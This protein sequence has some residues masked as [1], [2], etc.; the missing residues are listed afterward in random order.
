[1]EIALFGGTFDPPH[2][3]HHTVALSACQE[4]GFD[5]VWWIPACSPPHKS[6]GSVL[7]FA[8]RLAMVTLAVAGMAR[9]RVSG[10]ERGLSAPSY[11]VNT[12]EAFSR[13]Y[14]QHTF[15]LLIGEDSL[16]QFRTWRDPERIATMVTLTVYRRHGSFSVVPVPAY[17]RGR[18]RYCSAL[19]LRVSAASIRRQVSEGGDVTPLVCEPVRAYIATHGL[20]Q[21][22]S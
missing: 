20:Y 6:T 9:F 7:P 21:P 1:M 19:P 14:P 4:F 2:R 15:S 16:H 3:A 8:H 18:V 5:E 22:L 10:L 17:L 12:V 13:R 11:T